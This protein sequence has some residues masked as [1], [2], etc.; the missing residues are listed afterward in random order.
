[1]T[2]KRLY[3]FAIDADLAAALKKYKAVYGTGESEQIRRAVR[4]WLEKRGVLKKAPGSR[5]SSR[6]PR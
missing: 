3:T 6:K 5:A 2:P 4:T 1:M